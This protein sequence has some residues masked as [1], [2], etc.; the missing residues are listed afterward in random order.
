MKRERAAMFNR[1]VTSR[2]HT[3]QVD[4]DDYL[5]G[6]C[7]VHRFS[8]SGELIGSW[9]QPGVGPGQFNLPHGVRVAADGRVLV[10]DR[11]ND[12][13]QIFSPDGQFL[14]QWT[15][16]QRPTNV[17]I[18]DAGNVYVS[19]LWWRVGERSPVRGR[20]VE[21]RPGRVSVFG[22]AG[23]LLARWGRSRPLRGRQLRRAAR[24]LCRRAW[25]PL[26][27]RGRRHLRRTVRMCAAQLSHVPEVPP[28]GRRC[29]GLRR[30]CS[31]LQTPPPG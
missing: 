27:G 1:Y 26:R 10:A 29:R 31:S 5:Y 8:V 6:N 21:D 22:S 15:D 17:A 16:V 2:R 9:G 30:R 19:E 14:E 24:R 25:E 28:S 4:V 7:K 11:E 18:D 3:M 20:I 12:R 23:G 13:I